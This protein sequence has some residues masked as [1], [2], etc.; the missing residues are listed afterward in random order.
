MLGWQPGDG[1]TAGSCR[2]E[3]GLSEL[4]I[5]TASFKPFLKGR[6]EQ[7]KPKGA[8]SIVR[9]LEGA[10]WREGTEPWHCCRGQKVR[11]DWGRVKVRV[12]LASGRASIC[13]GPQQVE[14]DLGPR[15]PGTAFLPPQG[16]CCLTPLRSV[17]RALPMS[18]SPRAPGSAST[19]RSATSFWPWAC[20]PLVPIT[21]SVS[22]LYSPSWGGRAVTMLSGI[23]N[24]SISSPWRLR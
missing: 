7:G 23:G 20:L 17:A 12:G 13:P 18:C 10:F 1:A 8:G 21:K 16:K 2:P 9:R 19:L 15:S 14:G 24:R 4:P 3:C 5:H 22:S 6:M 11:G